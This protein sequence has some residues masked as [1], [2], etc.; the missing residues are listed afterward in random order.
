M[1][2]FYQPDQ[3]R[4]GDIIPFWENG[5]YHLFY[6]GHGWTRIDTRDQLHF[7][8]P[9]STG[10]RGGTG[11]VVK[12]GGLYHLFYCTFTFTP[13]C[14][15]YVCHAVSEDL[16]TWTP[17]P[18]DTFQPDDVIYEMS[19]WRDPHVVWNEEEGCWWM[20]IAAQRKGRTMRK[21]CVA[22][23]K[24]D[25]LHQWRICEPLYAPLTHPS[26]HECPDLFRWGDWWYLTYSVYTDRFRTLYR[27]ARSPK[28]PWITPPV[29]TFDTRCF[30]AAKHGTD[31]ES[32]FLYG[33]NPDRAENIWHF[34]PEQS[35]GKDYD[36]WD[37]GGVM[38]VHRLLQHPDGTLGVCPPD[39]VD[40]AFL[41]R[42][43]LELRPLN[44]T[45]QLTDTGASVR[46]PYAYASLLLNRVPARGKLELDV[47]FD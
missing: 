33:W 42:Q 21:G 1:N 44:G 37:W 45:W 46:T 39:A 5:L 35:R 27:M 20:L 12:S 18:E 9:V 17:L 8:A 10:I 25:D 26:A 2:L 6:L 15:Q 3:G 22:L 32:H 23:C 31:G 19:D 34:N 7:S 47:S 30:Y 14:R 11:S 16:E 4:C 24:S 13:Y 38:I 28:G 40:G 41:R 29:D 43:P 36:T